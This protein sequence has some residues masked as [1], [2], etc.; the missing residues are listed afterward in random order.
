MNTCKVCNSNKIST[1]YSLEAKKYSPG[2]YFNL[3]R[4][5]DCD[6]VFMDILYDVD[7][8]KKYYPDNYK[9]H[10]S[11]RSNTSI[12]RNT[13]MTKLRKYAFANY[14]SYEKFPTINIKK[15]ISCFYNKL[16]YRSIPFYIGDRRILDIG[17]GT[18]GYIKI[19]KALGW[20]VQ[21]VEPNEKVASNIK[22]S[23]FNVA[24]GSF[25]QIDYPENYF[26]V[27]TMWHVLEHLHDPNGV[28]LKIKRILKEDGIVLFGVPNYSS[29]DRQIFKGQWNGFEIPLHLNHF[30]PVSILN[31][32]KSAG[33][34]CKKIIHTVRPSDM[35]SSIISYFGITNKILNKQ[36]IRYL[37]IIFLLPL[38]ILS[39]LLKRSS[40][41]VVNMTKD[42]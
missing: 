28:L 18:G 38:S 30:T 1:I 32:A 13:I 8:I 37:L 24:C 4:C 42:T 34:K 2:S 39:S 9:P 40:I 21:G 29:L 20:E 23:G 22:R 33:F 19:L 15:I 3:I 17:C 11:G 41:I 6:L 14:Q 27:I 36:I 35:A 7:F 25:E 5:M 10:D 26:D 31:M 16:A 12:F